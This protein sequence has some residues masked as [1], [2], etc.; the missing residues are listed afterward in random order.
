MINKLTEIEIALSIVVPVAVAAVWFIAG[1]AWERHRCVKLV[2]EKAL[3]HT[4]WVVP[5][6]P[7]EDMLQLSIRRWECEAIEQDLLGG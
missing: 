3:R 6:M 1:I 4:R 7:K 2:R 5:G